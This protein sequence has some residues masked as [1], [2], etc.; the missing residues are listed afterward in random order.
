MSC[1]CSKLPQFLE[2]EKHPDLLQTLQKLEVGNWV[3]LY[4]CKNCGQH[5]RIHAWDKYQTQ[6]G[7]KINDPIHWQ[8]FDETPL[9]EKYDI[10]LKKLLIESRGGLTTE[11]CIWQGCNNFRVKGVVYCIDHLFQTGARK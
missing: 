1:A 4:R 8:E 7:V 3:E 11:K 9:R 2:V 5:W 6:F 10:E